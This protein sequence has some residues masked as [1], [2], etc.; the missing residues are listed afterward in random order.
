MENSRDLLV[1]GVAAAKS[2]LVGEARFYLEWV[3]R[4]DPPR[5]QKIDA[6]FWLSTLASDPSK[7]RELLESILAEEPFEPR[8]RRRLLILD[9]KLKTGDLIDP[10]LYQQE[11]NTT[12]SSSS[13]R[14]TCPNC[15]GRLTY[16]PDGSSLE[17]E[18][19]SSRQFFRRQTASLA[20][21]QASGNDFIMAMATAS[22]HNQMIAQQL[23][24]CKGCGAEFILEEHQISAN[25]PFCRSSQVINF[26]TIRQ[27]IP[28][29]RIIPIE[30]GYPQAFA[31]AKEAFAGNLDINKMFDVRPA[32]YPVWEFELNGT[33]GWRVPTTDLENEDRFSGDELINFYMVPVLAVDGLLES[34]SDLASEFDYSR[35]EP[36]KPQYLVDCLAVGYQVTMASAALEAREIAVREMTRR[37]EHKLGRRAGDFFVNSSGL[38]VSQFWL[39]LV[40]IWI[41][42]E[43]QTKR[44]AV[45]NGQNG[46]TRIISTD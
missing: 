40:P 34:C 20:N 25:C 27:M 8:A 42:L 13:D 12:A 41:F 19:C 24:T 2:R 46:K 37:M 39:T 4:L 10:E 9:G 6:L 44:A 43:A 1:R 28:P 18:Y 32:F 26:N 17:C 5:D 14:F 29:A 31:T 38:Y 35:I 23:L 11:I 36:Y 15:G 30:I 16:A 33:I 21:D 45:V 22:G 3:L 7:E